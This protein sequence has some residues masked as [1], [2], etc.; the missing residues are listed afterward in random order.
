MDFTTLQNVSPVYPMYIK[1]YKD[2]LLD[3]NSDVQTKM[4]SVVQSLNQLSQNEN[5]LV[6]NWNK[7]MQWAM[8]DGLDAAVSTQMTALEN[9]GYF[10]SLLTSLFNSEL[11]T[12]TLATSSQDIKG[13]INEVKGIAD[14][15]TSALAEMTKKQEWVDPVVD[16]G[17]DPTG[18]TD[19]ATVL[20]QMFNDISNGLKPKHVR[21][22]EGKFLISTI[23][24]PIECD[25]EGVYTANGN[26]GT[27]LM[28]TG[29]ST[30]PMISIQKPNDAGGNM[31]T[32]H[33]F[34]LANML[35]S[36]DGSANRLG[37]YIQG[38]HSEGHFENLF[39]SNFQQGGI[40]GQSFWD[41]TMAGVIIQDCGTD[42]TYPAFW[43]TASGGDNSNALHIFGC[44][45]EHN[46]YQLLID[47]SSRHIEF[48][49]CKFELG[50]NPTITPIY[51]NTPNEIVFNAC[52]FTVDTSLYTNMST[53]PYYIT[54]NNNGRTNFIGNHFTSEQSQ[55]GA[56]WIK[57]NGTTTGI[58]LIGNIFDY[59]YGGATGYSLNLLGAS[60]VSNNRFEI[61]TDGSGKMY[62]I[63][64][65]NDSI[66][67][68]NLFMV[69][70]GGGYGGSTYTGT[71]VYANG[72][73]VIV[74]DNTNSSITDA[75][76]FS[77]SDMN[78]NF[79][80]SKNLSSQSF[81]QNSATPSVLGYQTWKTNCT[82]ATTITDFLNGFNGQELNIVALDA[83]TTI[84]HGGNIVLT[85]KTPLALAVNQTIKLRK[86]TG[87]T[88]YQF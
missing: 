12:E 76:M 32:F 48:I 16:Y 75:N 2:T 42:G 80:L 79:Y 78:Y 61:L 60:I 41:S 85:G 10:N 74:K 31:Q 65:G 86:M 67:K 73:G 17:A 21:F 66:V 83:N 38:V 62:G 58:L 28:S 30:S 23:T 27:R 15:N 1:Q 14:S 50:T 63:S 71:A 25:I 35:I 52:H 43:L 20:Q 45:F 70:K 8:N 36:A 82:V 56:P 87:T 49:A 72:T 7:V 46:P 13:A 47:N 22:P 24:I 68:N 44:R 69:T 39:I 59:L 88:W 29:S 33:S 53:C 26:F 51:I 37:V 18:T 4:N 77:A 11:G 6:N 19:N 3:P 55:P 84:N 64:V 9:S 40:K 57:Q 34:H 54:L 5:D 81:T